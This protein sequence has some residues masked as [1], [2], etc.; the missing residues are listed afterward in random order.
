MTIKRDWKGHIKRAKVNRDFRRKH[1]Q[2]AFR[3]VVE[4]KREEESFG[5][6]MRGLLTRIFAV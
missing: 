1:A 5:V 3:Q 4:G 2:G 6:R